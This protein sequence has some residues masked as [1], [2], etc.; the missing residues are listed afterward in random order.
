MFD[1]DLFI[2]GLVNRSPSHA[3]EHLLLVIIPLSI[4]ITVGCS[5]GI[6]LTRPRFR[7]LTPQVM[8][9]LNAGQCI[10]PLAV[11]AIFL[12]FLGLGWGP[13]I[14][15]L[16][17]YC[18]LPITRNTIAGLDGVPHDVKESALGMGMSHREVF[19]KVEV[20][21]SLPVVLAGVKTSTVLTV[22]TAVLASLV[23]AGGMGTVI[24]AGIDFF[25]QELI[26]AGTL[27]IGAIAIF[28][29][30]LIT[31]VERIFVPKHLR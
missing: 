14:M 24:F 29:E 30:R 4:A 12:P 18:L 16:T 20:P 2:N 19:F 8:S 25:Q 9:V 13:A 28:F 11:I 7:W 15:A 3:V 1:M 21:L 6:I 5:I 10:P 23:A 27:V 17:I 31:L 26:V 22:G